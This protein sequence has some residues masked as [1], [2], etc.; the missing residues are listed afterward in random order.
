MAQTSAVY[1]KCAHRWYVIG[2]TVLFFQRTC[3]RV[4]AAH[5]PQSQGTMKDEVS[6][7]FEPM[8]TIVG[9]TSG[10]HEGTFPRMLSLASMAC[11]VTRLPQ[12]SSTF[13]RL[14]VIAQVVG[15]FPFPFRTLHQ[16]SVARS[17]DRVGVQG[18]PDFRT[19][20]LERLRLPLQI[21]EADCEC[22]AVLQ[23][24]HRAASPSP[25]R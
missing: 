4:S 14:V 7:H 17:S 15:P 5:P 23:G 25:G 10:R 3:T 6:Q 8:A 2:V 24:H 9:G 20:V 22:G 13:G 12:L 1:T 19:L 21:V 16:R 11:N 18:G